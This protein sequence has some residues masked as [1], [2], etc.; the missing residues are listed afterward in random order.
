MTLQAESKTRV[1]SGTALTGLMS[2]WD[3][4][5][6][7]GSFKKILRK[8][9]GKNYLCSELKLAWQEE[10]IILPAHVGEYPREQMSSV[11]NE[12]DP[13]LDVSNTFSHLI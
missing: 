6:R 9:R 11:L 7:E 1:T 13:L 2:L 4:R 10:G 3:S 12:F 8:T 5:G